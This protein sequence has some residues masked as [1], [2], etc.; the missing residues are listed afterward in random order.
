LYI[1]N[2]DFPTGQ[3]ITYEA[4]KV[5]SY[6]LHCHPGVIEILM[7]L[8]GTAQ[9]KSGFENFEMVAGDYIVIR[10]MDSH[11]FAA[12]DAKCEVLTVHLRMECYQRQIPYL[13]Y[14]YFA[15]ESFDLA[16]YKN[17]AQRLRRM[18]ASIVTQLIAESPKSHQ[19]AER[20]ARDLLWILVSDYDLKNYYSRKW[21][22]GYSK[23]EKYYKIMSYIVE[24]YPLKNLQ[25]YIAE[26]ECYSKSYITHLF[27]EVGNT[28]YKDI[29]DYVRVSMSEVPLLTTDMP[30]TEVSDKCGY[31][32]VKYYIANFKKWFLYTP[33]EYRKTYLPEVLKV[34]VVQSLDDADLL[35]R[36]EGF[37]RHPC[38][39]RVQKSVVNPL[40]LKAFSPA[41]S[42]I[43]GHSREEPAYFGARPCKTAG[44]GHS[45]LIS[46]PSCEAGEVGVDLLRLVA[47]FEDAGFVPVLTFNC[48]EG[49][50]KQCRKQM[51]NC[52]R[53]FGKAKLADFEFIVFY[54]NLGECKKIDQFVEEGKVILGS[55]SVRPIFIA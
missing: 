23:T 34:N 18:I 11:S 38:E 46:V 48:R 4:C 21:D 27:K 41:E 19:E 13:Q 30:I 53:L 6:H 2:V 42:L 7:I 31:S 24:K 3:P 33:A 25:E 40:A 1:E 50:I 37:L 49:S 28:S 51:E 26:H 52:L 17:E 22:A 9:V 54:N 55:D 16:E 29:V 45:A 47:Y 8:R 10:E 15:C 12:A 39:K 5:G 43:D 35:D 36:L 32:D 14:V 20:V 44:A